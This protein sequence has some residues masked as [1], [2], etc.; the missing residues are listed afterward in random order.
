M[1]LRVISKSI[2]EKVLAE[3]KSKKLVHPKANYF[4]SKEALRYRLNLLT[5]YF[6]K[7]T[8]HAIAIKTN[9]HPEVLKYIANNGFG[10]EAASIEEVK[11]AQ[12]AGVSP[13][14][15]VF[16]S[17][18]KTK[19]EIDYCHK[20]L[21]GA[22]INVNCFEEIKRYPK[23]FSCKLGLRIN[24]LVN[25]DTDKDLNV[26][27]LNSKF[28]IPFTK[29]NE[30][31]KLLTNSDQFTAIHFHIGSG[32]SD[33]A[34]NLKA[35]KI[36]TEFILEVNSERIKKGILKSIDTVD[37]GGGIDFELESENGLEMFTKGLSEASK[38]ID[39]KIVTE[40]GKFIHENNAFVS[41]SVEYITKN[42]PEIHNAFIHVGADLFLRKVY[43]SMNINY[44]ISVVGKERSQ[45]IYRIVGPLC[46]AGDVLYESVNLPILNEG[47]EIIINNTGA[48][49][50]SM[51]SKHCSRE[52][53]NF[54][55]F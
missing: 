37:I 15:I 47:D 51:W 19:S 16:D 18:V 54:I 13:S 49:T 8:L 33:F 4:Y 31:F 32:I 38:Y 39:F 5:E 30:I 50:L 41:S 10:L 40:F 2:A 36:L 3:A 28:G 9:N 26:S 34:P 42:T 43:S 7:N 6:P 52:E 44:P 22:L 46:F 21:P 1:N 29:K 17:P 12:K 55:F 11:L 20:N 27:K 53:I 24:P 45:Q 48:N 14:K 23:D 25:V 35:Y